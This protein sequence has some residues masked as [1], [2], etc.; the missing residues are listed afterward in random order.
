MQH[1]GVL[2]T[3]SVPPMREAIHMHAIPIGCVNLKVVRYSFIYFYFY[4]SQYGVHYKKNTVSNFH[5]TTPLGC[6]DIPLDYTAET[7]NKQHILSKVHGLPCQ[8]DS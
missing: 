6:P 3:A 4:L 1:L 8:V 2:S 7:R 5:R